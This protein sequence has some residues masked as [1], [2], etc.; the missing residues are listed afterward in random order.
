MTEELRLE[1]QEAVIMRMEK[2][3]YGKSFLLP[4]NNNEL[5][6]TNRNLILIRKNLLGKRE[7]TLYFPISEIRMADGHPQVRKGK[8]DHMTHTLDVYMNDKMESFRFEWESDIDEWIAQIDSVVTGEPVKR[9]TEADMIAE[10]MAIV[11]TI[12][13]P[14]EKMKG[15]LGIKSDKEVSCR[16]PSCGASLIGLKGETQKCPYCGTFHTF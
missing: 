7:E 2:V 12:E 15:I 11:E 8:A 3:G 9:K 6:L 14:I 10:A 16:C 13:E 1:P 5:I 4:A